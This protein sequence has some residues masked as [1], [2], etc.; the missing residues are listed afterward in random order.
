MTT[1]RFGAVPMKELFK[2]LG[3][4]EKEAETFLKL[5][6]LGAQPASVIARHMHVP[7]STMYLILDQLGKLNL[8]E[9][10]ERKGMKYFK[11]ISVEDIEAVL[12]L[13]EDEIKRTLGL[14]NE[15]LTDLKALE[16][17]L[18]VTPKVKFFEG[19]EAVMSMYESVLNEKNFYSFFNPGVENRVMKIYF[20]KVEKAIKKNKIK[21]SEF[22]VDCKEGRTYF[23]RANSKNHHIKIL[24]KNARF[25]SDTLICDDRICMISY[26]EKEV[27]AVVIWNDALVKTQKAMFEELWGRC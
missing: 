6:E 25:D 22:V 11:C 2:K 3:A 19:E 20:D 18:S 5:L 15:N 24:P 12:K 7:R 16:N 1:A 26:G 23:K 17:K 27:S 13:R 9:E 10:F 21:A 14:L 4:S 8:V